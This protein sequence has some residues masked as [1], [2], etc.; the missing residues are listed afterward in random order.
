MPDFSFQGCQV[1]I[2][3]F[4]SI[5]MMIPTSKLAKPYIVS[6]EMDWECFWRIK[7][8]NNASFL[9]YRVARYH[10]FQFFPLKPLKRPFWLLD[11]T[12]GAGAFFFHLNINKWAK[13]FNLISHITYVWWLCGVRPA[14]GPLKPLFWTWSTPVAPKLIISVF[15]LIT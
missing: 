9:H 3:Q 7:K 10:F 5:K 1:F 14:M 6:Q 11:Q 12:K 4:I 2:F 13:S 8:S 15:K